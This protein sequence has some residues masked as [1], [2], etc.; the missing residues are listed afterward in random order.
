MLAIA[1]GGEV[2][3]ES[4]LYVCGVVMM[5]MMLSHLGD[6]CSPD[7]LFRETTAGRE[8]HPTD[9]RINTHIF[10]YKHTHTHT[11]TLYIVSHK[12]SHT[13]MHLHKGTQFYCMC[14]EKSSVHTERESWY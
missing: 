7:G 1:W 2:L 6:H 3:Y 10:T 12:L 4:V 13:L 9:T 5:M 8:S 14:R 11:S